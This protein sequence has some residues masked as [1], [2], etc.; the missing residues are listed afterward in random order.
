LSLTGTEWAILYTLQ[1]ERHELSVIDPK[2]RW[3][4][5]PDKM[6]IVCEWIESRIKE[7][8]EKKQ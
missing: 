3:N 2:E 6:K 8:E 5:S 7:L 4:I 1:N